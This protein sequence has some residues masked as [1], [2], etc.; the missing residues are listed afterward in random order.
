MKLCVC[1]LIVPEA[2]K[3]SNVESINQ[4]HLTGCDTYLSLNL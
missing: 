2:T 4:W 1:A 3:V